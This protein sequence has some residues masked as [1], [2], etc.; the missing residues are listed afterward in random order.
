[1]T[2]A[3]CINRISASTAGSPIAGCGAVNGRPQNTEL[4]ISGRPGI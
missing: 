3:V 2:K 4:T 1:M